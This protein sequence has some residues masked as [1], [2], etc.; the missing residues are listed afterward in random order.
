MSATMSSVDF[1][2]TEDDTKGRQRRRRRPFIGSIVGVCFLLFTVCFLAFEARGHR[3]NNF[4]I[5]QFGLYV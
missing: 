1:S 5:L 3:P 4:G 2:T